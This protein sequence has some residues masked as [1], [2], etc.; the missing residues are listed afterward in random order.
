[1]MVRDRARTEALE[2]SG[3]RVLRF[4]NNEVFENLDG[5]CETILSMAR[6]QG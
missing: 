2:A 3:Y 6:G 4:W 1:M 5:V